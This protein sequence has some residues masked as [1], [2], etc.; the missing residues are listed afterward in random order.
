MWKVSCIAL[1]IWLGL[2]ERA[3]QE[4]F[5]LGQLLPLKDQA[6]SLT[7]LSFVICKIEIVTF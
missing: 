2:V 5:Q 3:K 4:I 1:G 7:F 6:S